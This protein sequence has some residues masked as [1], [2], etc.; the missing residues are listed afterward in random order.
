LTVAMDG[1]RYPRYV[2]S[3]QGGLEFAKRAGGK[4]SFE[5]VA[6]IMVAK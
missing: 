1:D 4:Y 5:S 3:C 2:N 6:Y